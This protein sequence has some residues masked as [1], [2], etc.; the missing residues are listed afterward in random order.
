M[1]IGSYSTSITSS[2]RVAVPKRFREELGDKF[3]AAKW[4]ERCLVMVS[5]S[6]WGEMVSKLTGSSKIITSTVRDTE[7]FILG[8]AYELEPDAQG[9]VVLPSALVGYAELKSDVVFL[10]LGDRIEVWSKGNWEVRESYVADNAA[11]LIERIAKDAQ[12]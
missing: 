1:V 12:S 7:R 3:V 10:G 6:S 9:R 5:L 11:E 4:Y 8:S 2:R